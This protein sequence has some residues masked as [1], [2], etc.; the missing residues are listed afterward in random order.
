MEIVLNNTDLL[1][2]IFKYLPQK[3]FIILK[4]VCHQWYIINS[5]VVT[6]KSAKE[7]SLYFGQCGYLNC[8]KFFHVNNYPVNEYICFISSLTGHLDC[9]KY[10]RGNGY[11]WDEDVCHMAAFGG[12]LDCLKYAHKNGCPWGEKTCSTAAYSGHLDCRRR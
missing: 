2:I 1:K 4:F 5:H 9:L 3:Y 8:L 10:V 12:F 6:I 7:L 11:P